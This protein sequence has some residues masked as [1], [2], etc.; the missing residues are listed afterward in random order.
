MGSRIKLVRGD[1]AP[2]I[3]VS[4]TDESNGDPIDVS[5]SGT[6]VYMDFRQ[7]GTTTVLTTIIGTKMIGQLAPDGTIDTTVVPAGKGGRVAFAWPPG[8]LDVDPGYYEGQITINFADGTTQTV[9]QLL[10]FSVRADF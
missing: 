3:I 7:S 1:T 6:I 9:Y 8:S 5:A 10:K 4:M 2:Q